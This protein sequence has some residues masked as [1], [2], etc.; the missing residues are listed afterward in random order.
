[1]RRRLAFA[2]V[3][4]LATGA[5]PARAVEPPRTFAVVDLSDPPAAPAVRAR[6][7]REVAAKGLAAV[8]DAVTLRALGTADSPMTMVR[9]LSTEA[10]QARER[11]DC[12]TGLARA[13]EAE[14]A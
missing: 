7:E 3:V 2:L 13:R 1:M 4:G 6:V 9:R 10:R 5:S 11:G 14:E 12:A 8:A